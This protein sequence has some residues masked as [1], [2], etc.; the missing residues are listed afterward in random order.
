MSCLFMRLSDFYREWSTPRS[1]LWISRLWDRETFLVCF[2][3]EERAK[4]VSLSSVLIYFN[5]D[6]VVA[7]K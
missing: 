4:S 1:L 7:K 5:E 6:L 2:L 3:Q